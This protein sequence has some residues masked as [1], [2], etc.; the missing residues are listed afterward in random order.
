MSLVTNAKRIFD[1]KKKDIMVTVAPTFKS[2]MLISENSE[3][4]SRQ[5][6]AS[7]HVKGSYGAFTGAASASLESSGGT[8]TSTIR[9]NHDLYAIKFKSQLNAF[10]YSSIFRRGLADFLLKQS[11]QQICDMF[12]QF[13]AASI[14]FGGQ[15][16]LTRIIEKRRED[17]ASSLRAEVSASYNA[18][19]ASVSASAGGS[20]AS[21]S[22]I[23]GRREDV[24]LSV[25][26]G[27][28][29]YW[30]GYD[31]RNYRECQRLWSNSIKE[32]EMYPME[33]HL[34]PLWK[35]FEG[36]PKLAGKASALKKYLEGTW[37]DAL[38]KYRQKTRSDQKGQPFVNGK[39]GTSSTAANEDGGTKRTIYLDRHTVRAPGNAVLTGFGL[40]RP[41]GN[42]INYQFSHVTPPRVGSV[43]HHETPW[44]DEDRAGGYRN[45]Y[46]DRHR[47]MAPSGH[48]LV[49]FHL[50]RNG[51]NQIAYDFWSRPAAMG[52]TQERQTKPNDWGSGRVIYLDRHL[53]N[54]P[55]GCA[56]RGFQLYRPT[57]DTISYRYWFAPMLM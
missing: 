55:K 54:V 32:D 50:K 56:L 11:P 23:E 44:N 12:G 33:L 5:V 57:G 7:L 30:L 24:N 26:G 40:R 53:F 1:L 18:V 35:A 13:F 41:T 9:C 25:R 43:K 2:S 17:T 8:E 15:V 46:L 36:S 3:M 27:D 49:G 14:S 51:R 16:R 21:T 34:E 29:K 31:G 20:S 28:I 4:H 38:A 37:A 6:A 22:A 52:A 47:V 19:L 48:F 10:E 45:I 39:I 42:T